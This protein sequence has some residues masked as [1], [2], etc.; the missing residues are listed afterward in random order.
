MKR[1]YYMPSA[2][3]LA[4]SF[5][6]EYV[7]V[8][9]SNYSYLTADLFG[10]LPR[11]E[12]LLDKLVEVVQ[13]L[14]KDREWDL[15]GIIVSNN[16]SVAFLNVFDTL[17]REKDKERDEARKIYTSILSV[18][19]FAP[20]RSASGRLDRLIVKIALRRPHHWNYMKN[21]PRPNEAAASYP[22]RLASVEATVMRLNIFFFFF[23]PGLNETHLLGYGNMLGCV[24]SGMMGCT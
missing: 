23:F 2:V 15:E 21:P 16:N 13:S 22:P 6:D 14:K 7:S 3:F 10:V 9:I 1:T 4:L 18:L 11:D 19:K 17:H 12:T 20:R 24:C 5:R 8:A